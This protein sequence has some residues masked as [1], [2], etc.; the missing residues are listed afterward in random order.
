ML[1]YSPVEMQKVLNNIFRVQ[2]NMKDFQKRWSLKPRYFSVAVETDKTIT[3]QTKY[4]R[5]IKY[6]NVSNLT[7]FIASYVRQSPRKTL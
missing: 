3:T 1:Q 4:I 6:L 5:R 2:V 7:F